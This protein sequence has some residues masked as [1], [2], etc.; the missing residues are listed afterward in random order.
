MRLFVVGL[1][2]LLLASQAVFASVD[3]G[4]L[5]MAPAEATL[6]TGVDVTRTA[7]SH[8]GA[9]M[10]RQMHSDQDFDK[11]IAL[12]G[13]DPRRDLQQILFVGLGRQTG[14][15]SRFAVLARGSFDPARL[16]GAAQAKG[17][18]LT[19][20]HGMPVLVQNS[21]KRAVGIAFP[22]ADIVVVGDLETVHRVIAP[23]GSTGLDPKL[24]EQVNRIGSG[25]DVWFATLLS[26]SFL[27][28]QLGGAA[29]ELQGAQ[30]LQSILESS[31]GLQ[32]GDAL[33][34]SL[35]V[36]ARSPEDARSLS[37]LLHFAGNLLQM[38]SSSTAGSLLAR[39]AVG[40]MQV[41]TDGS[42]L[43]AS[44]ALPEAQVEQAI[45]AGKH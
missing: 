8:L 36:I 23:E 29:P 43:H 15:D 42:N 41:T 2:I 39:S 44:A 24:T 35:D 34:V 19:H 18:V 22:Q 32:F 37:D 25:N 33:T 11:F 1:P 30:A 13:F 9:Y 40:T 20:Y 7:N 10:L 17:A 26:G 12:T 3:S 21:G 31:G 45:M 28:Q 4:L 38:H 14:S 5:A 16:T 6:L 27:G